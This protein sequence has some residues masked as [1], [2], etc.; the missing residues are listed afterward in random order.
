MVVII[1]KFGK[2]LICLVVFCF[3]LKIMLVNSGIE[4]E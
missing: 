3:F 1:I 2:W 4:G